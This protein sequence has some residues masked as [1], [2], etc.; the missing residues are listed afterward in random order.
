MAEFEG[1]ERRIDRINQVIKKY[2]LKDLDNCK[3]ICLDGG[4]DVEKFVKDVQPICFENAE[5]A[6]FAFER[7]FCPSSVVFL[8]FFFL[9]LN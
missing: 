3:K 6:F 8:S 1:K 9:A 2:K 5:T 7:A 4:I